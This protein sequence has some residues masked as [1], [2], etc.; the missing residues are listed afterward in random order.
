MPFKAIRLKQVLSKN[1]LSHIV[2]NAFQITFKT[3]S[4][5]ES[6]VNT[7]LLSIR[8]S[9]FVVTD[10]LVLLKTNQISESD[11]MSSQTSE[12]RNLT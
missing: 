4:L 9:H 2:L 12:S 5:C 7:A 8:Y 10:N 11:V 3:R 1:V 6:C